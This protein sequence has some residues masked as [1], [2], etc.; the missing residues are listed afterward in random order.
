MKGIYSIC[1]SSNRKFIAASARTSQ[2][3]N[4][5]TLLIFDIENYKTFPRKPKVIT[6]DC[7]TSFNDDMFYFLNLLDS[8]FSCGYGSKTLLRILKSSAFD[9]NNTFYSKE[10]WAFSFS[11]MR[12]FISCQHLWLTQSDEAKVELAGLD[13]LLP[14][15]L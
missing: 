14:E 12:F 13:V 6:Y 3:A 1:I 5:A 11:F 7:E 2:S 15:C 10:T 9:L 4:R 8:N